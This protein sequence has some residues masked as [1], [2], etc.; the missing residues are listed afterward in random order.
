MPVENAGYPAPV[1]PSASRL[2]F[3][4]AI[5]RG[6]PLALTSDMSPI[7]RALHKR[8]DDVCRAEL[9]RLRKKT[10]ALAPADRDQVDA[11]SVEVTQAIAASVLAVVD[12]PHGADLSDIV[13]RLFAITAV[14]PSNARSL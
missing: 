12:D 9:A 14:D 4:A 8:F 1:P 2:E 10:A 7:A 3:L 6:T 11:I 13:G 5:R